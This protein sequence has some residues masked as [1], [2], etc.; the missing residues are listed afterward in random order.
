MDQN[1]ERDVEFCQNLGKLFYAIALTDKSIREDEFISLKKNIPNLISSLSFIYNGSNVDIEHHVISTFNTLDLESYNA[2]ACFNDFIDYK[3]KN[4]GLFKKSI[5]QSLL[6]IAS[7]I[8]SSFS[9]QNKSELIMLA[10][11][12][13]EFKKVLK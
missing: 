8:A 9:S 13:L 4:E 6:K 3:R 7:K 12:D 11:L 10:K 5:K 2:Q 1:Q